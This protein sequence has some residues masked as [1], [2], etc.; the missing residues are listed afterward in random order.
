MKKNNKQSTNVKNS[1]NKNTN[2]CKNNCKSNNVSN[3]SNNKTVGFEDESKSFELDPNE[4]H[5]FELR[6]CK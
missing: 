3:K 4:D 5:S 2:N 1:M 6:D